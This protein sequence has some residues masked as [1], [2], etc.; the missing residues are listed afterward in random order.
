MKRITQT[1]LYLAFPAMI[2]LAAACSVIQQGQQMAALAKCDFRIQSVSNI[3]LMGVNV[4]TIKSVSDLSLFDAQKLIRNVTAS[5]VPLNATVNVQAKNPNDRTAG[6]TK[7]EWILF[8]D[9]IQM[10]QGNIAQNITIPPNNGEAVIPVNF[11]VDLK[12]VL[13]GKS[14]D[15]LINFGLNLAGV[16]SKPTRFLIKLKPTIMIGSQGIVYPGYINVRTEYTSQ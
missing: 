7:L 6:M 1:V 15:A 13:Q 10:T 5:Q 8:I 11:S 3:T 14:G 4:Q 9:D 12:K 2:V 16:G